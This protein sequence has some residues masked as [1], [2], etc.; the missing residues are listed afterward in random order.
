MSRTTSTW[1]VSFPPIFET[2]RVDLE[3]IPSILNKKETFPSHSWVA[4]PTPKWEHTFLNIYFDSQEVKINTRR[5]CYITYGKL[6]EQNRREENYSNFSLKRLPRQFVNFQPNFP[7]KTERKIGLQGNH[8]ASE[9]APF[10]FLRQLTCLCKP[11]MKT[12]S[13]DSANP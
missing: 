5:H 8:S 4:Q 13:K 6:L 10:E 9:F 1:S 11:G 3:H 12:K 7:P 2:S